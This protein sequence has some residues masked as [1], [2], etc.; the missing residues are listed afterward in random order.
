M[1]RL[2]ASALLVVLCLTACAV[3]LSASSA[4]PPLPESY[5]P[6]PEGYLGPWPPIDGFTTTSTDTTDTVEGGLPWDDPDL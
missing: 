1:K 3:L 2:I 4:T 5:P 6:P